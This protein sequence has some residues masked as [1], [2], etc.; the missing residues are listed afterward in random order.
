MRNHT[1]NL[2]KETKA[3]TSSKARSTR[4]SSDQHWNKGDLSWQSRPLERGA[5]RLLTIAF[6][7]Q[8]WLSLSTPVEISSR[9]D[10]IGL[11]S[12]APRHKAVAVTWMHVNGEIDLYVMKN[13][14]Q[15]YPWGRLSWKLSSAPHL[16]RSPHQLQFP[17]QTVQWKMPGNSPDDQQAVQMNCTLKYN[18]LVMPSSGYSAHGYD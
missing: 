4:R 13:N 12:W 14:S 7:S 1:K 3:L 18:N 5:R 11:S 15:G 2:H 6:F 16:Q 9:P 8:I 10:L 17:I